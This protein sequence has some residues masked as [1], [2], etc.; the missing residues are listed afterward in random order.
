MRSCL[1]AKCQ[2]WSLSACPTPGNVVT[3]ACHSAFVQENASLKAI[4]ETFVLV[5]NLSRADDLLALATATIQDAILLSVMVDEELS[6]SG[7][8]KVL[9]Q[10]L[11]KLD[12]IE[13]SFPS[14]K[15]KMQ[16]LLLHEVTQLVVGAA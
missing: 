6:E 14:L 16:P 5:V 11:Q 9:E 10:Q 13:K 8:K 7:R 12:E 15:H 2:T 1:L 4:G 3:L